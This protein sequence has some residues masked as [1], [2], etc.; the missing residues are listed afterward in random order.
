M[1][2]GAVP[3]PVLPGAVPSPALPSGVPAEPGTLPQ[4]VTAAELRAAFV[5]GLRYG[6]LGVPAGRPLLVVDLDDDPDPGAP[7]PP[8]PCLVVG[9]VSGVPPARPW[10]GADILLS[11]VPDPPRPWVGPSARWL[12]RVEAAVTA[13][14]LASVAAGQLLRLAG[15]LPAATGLLAES[16]AYSMLQAGP[17]HRR[18]LAQRPVAAPA[19][20][21]GATVLVE[22]DGSRLSVVLNRPDRH[23][24][25]GAAMRDELVAALAVAVAD[26]TIEQIELSGAGPSFCSGGDLS[27]FGTAPDPATAHAV[28]VAAGA[29]PWLDRCS[30]RICVRVHGSCVGAGVELASFASRVVAS[31]DTRFSLPE[32][33]MGLVPGAGGTVS[34]PRRIG[35]QRS[36]LLAVTGATLDATTALGWGLVDEVDDH[37]RGP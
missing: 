28:R 36:T 6:D 18:W 8:H 14:P 1:P 29:A 31:A 20:D 4:A 12:P 3:S 10:A 17:E 35:R 11:G 24:A 21:R 15:N 9:L 37:P 16:F 33:G 30:P 7:F 22:R 23:N 2:G 13:S 27:E 5:S 19:H 25:Y 32:V 26:P 34:V